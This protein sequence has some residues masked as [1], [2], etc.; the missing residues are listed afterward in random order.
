MSNGTCDIRVLSVSYHDENITEGSL[1]YGTAPFSTTTV[2]PWQGVQDY[3][4]TVAEGLI[5]G[6]NGF[7]SSNCDFRYNSVGA[8]VDTPGDVFYPSPKISQYTII[9]DVSPGWFYFTYSP[10]SVFTAIWDPCPTFK[11]G[12]QRL[13]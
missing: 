4:L 7:W 12:I 9:H 3:S 10:Y 6:Q 11:H 5:N 2:V 13:V 8:I 1:A